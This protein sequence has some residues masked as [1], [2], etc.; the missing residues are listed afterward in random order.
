MA[1]DRR[2]LALAGSLALG[3]AL[4]LPSLDAR[5]DIYSF[6]D[7][8]GV[9]HFTNIPRDRNSDIVVFEDRP[10]RK[11]SRGAPSRYDDLIVRSAE[12]HGVDPSLVKAVIHV[13]SGFNHLARSHKGA[14]GLMQL[15]PQTA[16]GL[17]VDYPYS[18]WENI[19]GGTRYLRKMIDRFGGDLR[20]ALAAYNSGPNN[21]V[22]YKGI[23]PFRETQNYVREVRKRHL[24][25]KG[26][27]TPTVTAS[28]S[29]RVDEGT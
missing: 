5:A 16:R 3:L 1:P 26:T 13:E 17:D 8:N 29:V 7:S 12:R 18:P 27:L 20:L 9:V 4:A 10:W 25:Y 6:V 22:K 19:D 21:V 14:M 2:P 24:E 11:P 23:P 28:T 15:M